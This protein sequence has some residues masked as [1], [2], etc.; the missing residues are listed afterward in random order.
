[1]IRCKQCGYWKQPGKL[2]TGGWGVCMNMMT[3]Q[4]VEHWKYQKSLTFKTF[5]CVYAK[6]VSKKKEPTP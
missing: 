1:M 2:C 4:D 5:G 6:K 3:A